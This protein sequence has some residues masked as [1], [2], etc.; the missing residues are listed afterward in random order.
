M[1]ASSTVSAIDEF[2]SIGGR[3]SGIESITSIGSRCE[4]CSSEE[5]G[6]RATG[7]VTLGATDV[8]SCLF[9]EERSFEG[10]VTRFYFV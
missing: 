3:G 9:L 10:F 5:R 8:E 7:S 2:R 1:A 4:L 6:F